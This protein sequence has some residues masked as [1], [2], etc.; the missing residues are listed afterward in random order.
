MRYVASCGNTSFHWLVFFFAA[1][2]WGSKIHKYTGRW[3]WQGSASVVPWNWW[4]W[5]NGHYQ[6]NK[7]G[8]APKATLGTLLRNGV[9]RTWAFQSAQTPSWA[10]LNWTERKLVTVRTLSTF[11]SIYWLNNPLQTMQSPAPSK[12]L[13]QNTKINVEQDLFVVRLHRWLQPSSGHGTPDLSI[14]RKSV[15][16]GRRRNR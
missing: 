5:S 3:M 10:E 6:S 2:L 14:T 9:E 4:N 12:Y 13:T 8:T 16:L 15:K 7:L 1:L 11:S